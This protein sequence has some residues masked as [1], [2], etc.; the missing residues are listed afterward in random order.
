MSFFE[1]F[2]PGARHQ[3]EER[4]RQNTL[5]TRPAAGAG[6]PL[7]IDLNTGKATFSMPAVQPADDVDAEAPAADGLEGFG[8]NANPGED[9][10]SGEDANPAEDNQPADDGELEDAGAE[11][12]GD[13]V[14]TRRAPKAL[15]DL[16]P[17]N[18]VNGADS[19]EPRLDLD[20][21]G[22]P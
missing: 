19:R 17:S 14:A 1:F 4:D 6:G 10:Q 2:Q 21:H 3:R 13:D 12:S 11:N 8:E 15:G 22:G 18:D 16:D 9:R 7:G 5:V 20:G